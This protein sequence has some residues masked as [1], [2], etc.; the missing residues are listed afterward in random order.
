MSADLLQ[1]LR[2]ARETW[3]TV[4]GRDFLL[5]RPT[6]VQLLRVAHT[7]GT[8]LLRLCL[9][10]WRGI[11]LQDLA[12]G[13]SADP[14]PFDLDVAVEWLEDDPKLFSGLCEAIVRMLNARV[15]RLAEAKKK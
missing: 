6:D 4:E 7:A 2:A 13:E 12:P 3:T 1:R 5:R 9:V 14:A 8:D 11:T 10:G 15:E